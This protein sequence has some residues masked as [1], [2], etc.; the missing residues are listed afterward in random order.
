[1]FV[2]Y[3]CG[4]FL[5]L[6]AACVPLALSGRDICGSAI[7]GSGKVCCSCQSQYVLAL[8]KFHEFV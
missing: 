2:L 7:T 8:S 5:V 4:E 6:Q 3:A 1:M